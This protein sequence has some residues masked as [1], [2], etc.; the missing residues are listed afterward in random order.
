MADSNRTRTFDERSSSMFD[1]LGETYV[2]RSLMVAARQLLPNAHGEVIEAAC[3]ALEIALDQCG[4]VTTRLDTPGGRYNQDAASQATAT[5]LEVENQLRYAITVLSAARNYG[6]PGDPCVDAMN[7]AHV[8]RDR[9]RQ[10]RRSLAILVAEIGRLP[11][12]A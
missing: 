10:L 5:L 6:K 2:I 9:S 11:R 3:D 12:A 7:V 1:Q 8:A 4:A